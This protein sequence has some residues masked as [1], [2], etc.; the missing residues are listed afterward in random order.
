M[1]NSKRVGQRQKRDGS[2]RR[3]EGK[4]KCGYGSLRKNASESM[5]CPALPFTQPVACLEN[6]RLRFRLVNELFSM[7]GCCCR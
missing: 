3:K 2:G 1:M 5:P 7:A 4:P 6:V